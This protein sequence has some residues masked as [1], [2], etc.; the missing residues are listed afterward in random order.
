MQ[1][2]SIYPV[3]QNTRLEFQQML[4]APNEDK[5]IVEMNEESSRDMETIWKCIDSLALRWRGGRDCHFP[6]MPTNR[7]EF[8][9]EFAGDHEPALMPALEEFI[10]HSDG[11]GKIAIDLGCGNSPAVNSL[12]KKW[13]KIIRAF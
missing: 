2:N 9:G 5:P 13:W 8:W 11:K 7:Q 4:Q 12:L 10:K 3:N 6:G 1:I